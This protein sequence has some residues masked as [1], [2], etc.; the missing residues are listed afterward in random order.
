MPKPRTWLFVALGVLALL[1]GGAVLIIGA[2]AWFF[3]SHVKVED[4]TPAAARDQFERV[5]ARFEGQAPLIEVGEHN[6]VS[7]AELHRRRASYTGPLPENLTLM[8]WD[9]GE[10]KVVNLTFPFW[11]LRFQSDKAMK[12]DVDGF[13][14]DQLGVSNEDIQMAGPALVLDL[15]KDD[16]RV[17]MWTE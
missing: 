14:L 6:T 9:Q 3:A 1:V 11:M 5:R 4:A 8:V 17:L 2:G 12:I 7:A 15:H 16:V 13:R 10:D